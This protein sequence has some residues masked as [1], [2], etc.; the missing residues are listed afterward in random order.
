VDGLPAGESV[1]LPII[2]NPLAPGNVT[3]TATADSGDAVSESNETDNSKDLSIAVVDNINLA[4]VPGGFSVDPQ[5][6]DGTFTIRFAITNNGTADLNHFFRV[7]ISW[8]SKVNGEGTFDDEACCSHPA[9]DLAAGS[10]VGFST[11]ERFPASG[12]YALILLIDP[13]NDIAESSE[14]DNGDFETLHVP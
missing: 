3:Y 6:D 8:K 10:S 9:P 4:F 14:T 13:D 7:G 11:Q 1:Q 2:I 5:N 12:D